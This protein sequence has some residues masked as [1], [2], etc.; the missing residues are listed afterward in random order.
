[1]G[2]DNTLNQYSSWRGLS[3]PAPPP[4]PTPVLVA[5]SEGEWNKR[6]DSADLSREG[7]FPLSNLTC[8]ILTS[9]YKY[10]TRARTKSEGLFSVSHFFHTT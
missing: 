3:A 5:H 10:H 2:I 7:S 6:P 4:P 8:C 1:M 9:V